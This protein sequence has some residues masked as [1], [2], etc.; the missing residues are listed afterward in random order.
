M[1]VPKANYILLDCIILFS[2]ILYYIIL[3]YIILTS[4]QEESTSS[5]KQEVS[6]LCKT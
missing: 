5:L 6:K 3:Y 4:G 1:L 2:I